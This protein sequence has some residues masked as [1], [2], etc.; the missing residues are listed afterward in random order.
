MLNTNGRRLAA[1]EEFVRRLASYLPGFELYLQFDS[2]VPATL[3]QL[4]GADLTGERH[5]AIEMLNRHNLSTTLVVMLKK[6]VND[7][8][9][10]QILDFAAKQRCVR[11]V[12]FQ[13]IQAAGRLEGFDPAMDRLTL[14]E[15]RRAILRQSNLFNPQDLVPVPCHP[16]ALTMGYAIRR[17]TQIIPLSR[18]VDPQ[19]LLNV[20]GNTISYEQNPN[21]RQHVQDIVRASPRSVARKLKLQCCLP[22]LPAN[23]SP[24]NYDNVFR[25]IIMQ[26]MDAWNMD[27][28]SLKRSCVHIVDPQGRLVP[29]E[30]YNLL[31]RKPQSDHKL[32]YK[33]EPYV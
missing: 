24:I 22:L 7:Q 3:R 1:D 4:R 6:G 32:Q 16:D 15:V 26:F 14:T 33:K 13:P 20:G 5:R 10:G 12:T 21:L 25:V 19:S 9:I 2:L 11:G 31:Y 29:M 27:L 18:W 23:G 30:T 28:R 17:G 8:E